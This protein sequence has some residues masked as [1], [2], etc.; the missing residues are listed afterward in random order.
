MTGKHEMLVIERD[1]FQGE[2]AVIKR[3]YRLDLDKRDAD[4]FVTS[5]SCWT[6]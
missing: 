1:N 3:V 6:H 4:G 2:A 5:R